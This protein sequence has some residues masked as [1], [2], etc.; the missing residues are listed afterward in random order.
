MTGVQ[1][2]AL[3]IYKQ[4]QG[5]TAEEPWKVLLLKIILAA[6]MVPAHHWLEHRVVVYLSHHKKPHGHVP[7]TRAKG[8]EHTEVVSAGGG[9]R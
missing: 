6:G 2:C 4:I 8:D 5:W 3:P 1:T 9:V 7:A